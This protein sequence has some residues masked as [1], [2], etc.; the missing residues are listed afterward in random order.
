MTRAWWA[1][2]NSFIHTVRVAL[3]WPLQD[4][5]AVAQNQTSPIEA[6]HNGSDVAAFERVLRAT[7]ETKMYWAPYSSPYGSRRPG[8][9]LSQT[10]IHPDNTPSPHLAL[11]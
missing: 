7:R 4:V 8:S 11:G 5:F 9:R 1:N 2:L 6:R 10:R 3:F